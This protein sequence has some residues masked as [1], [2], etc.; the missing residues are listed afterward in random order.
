MSDKKTGGPAFPCDNC[1]SNLGITMRDY[2]AAK[3][4]NGMLSGR[5]DDLQITA[6]EWA[7]VAYEVADAMLVAREV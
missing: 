4:L 2:F 5:P 7:K 3:A 1:N 6:R